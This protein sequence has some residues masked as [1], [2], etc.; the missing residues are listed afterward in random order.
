MKY[1][2]NYY[3]P[4]KIYFGQGAISNLDQE[5]DNYGPNVLLMYGGGSIKQHGLYDNVISYLKKHNKN[6]VELSGVM[7]NPTYEKMLEGCRLV[8][9]NNIDLIFA[10]GGGSVIDCAKGIAASAYCEEDPWQYYYLGNKPIKNKVVPIGTIL[11]MTGTCSE[12]NGGSVITNEATNHKKGHVFESS[13]YPK[14][15]ILDPDYTLTVPEYQVLSGAF[16]IFSH[17]MEQYFSGFDINVSDYVLESLMKALID[18][19]KVLSKD[20]YNYE[21][22]SNLVWISTMALNTISGV[23]KKQDWQVHSI[24][25]Q[26]SAFTN[27]AHGM[28]LASISVPYYKYIYKNGL[29][30]FVRFAR[31]VFFVKRDDTKSKEDIALEGIN[32]LDQFIREHKMHYSLKE[33]GVTKDMLPKI[34]DSVDLGSAGAYKVLNSED[35]LQILME[36]YDC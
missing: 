26:I 25:H 16:D 35:I 8:K 18:T 32:K 6:I 19:I 33:L 28:G 21:A 20:L 7:P 5:L 23:S 17:L 24:E 31:T 2:F 3:N 14:F 13:N 12:M 27:C 9:E 4:T 36:A 29:S 30:K 15:S 1:S 10:V 34:A 22:R 11:T